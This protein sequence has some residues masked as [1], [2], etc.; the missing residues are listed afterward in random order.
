MTV[1]IVSGPPIGG[2]TNEMKLKLYA[3][4]KQATKGECTEKEP[5]RLQVVQR[6]KWRALHLLISFHFFVELSVPS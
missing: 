4:F 3:L 2:I 5:S 1:P 6:M